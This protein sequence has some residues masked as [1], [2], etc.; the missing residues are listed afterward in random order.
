MNRVGSTGL[1]VGVDDTGRTDEQQS[2]LALYRCGY[3]CRIRIE[4]RW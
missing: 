2:N 1:Y 3:R 4:M